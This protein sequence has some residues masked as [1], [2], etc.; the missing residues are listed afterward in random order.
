MQVA[1][2]V[3][4]EKAFGHWALYRTASGFGLPT[5]GAGARNSAAN[6]EQFQEI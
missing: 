3:D 1:A 5:L 2:H 4:D 6:L